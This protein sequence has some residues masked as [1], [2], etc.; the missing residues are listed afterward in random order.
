MGFTGQLSMEFRD[1]PAGPRWVLSYESHRSSNAPRRPPC[2]GERTPVRGLCYFPTHAPAHESDDLALKGL[3][4]RPSATIQISRSSRVQR[5]ANISLSNT[6][7]YRAPVR[8]SGRV[9]TGIQR[10]APQHLTATVATNS[11]TEASA[12][13]SARLGAIIRELVTS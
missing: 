10:R 7:G 4:L 6:C 13:S 9:P 3:H 11:A 5:L 12:R 1:R 2:C 8:E